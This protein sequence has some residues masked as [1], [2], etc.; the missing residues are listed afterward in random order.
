[1]KTAR[2]RR[3]L[4]LPDSITFGLREHRLRQLKES[5]AVGKRWKGPKPNEEG[6]HVFTTAIGTPLEARNI[7]RA[8]TAI[9][10]RAGLPHRR[11]AAS[12]L[13]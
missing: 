6:C 8:Y 3:T 2:S 7:V 9:V 5:L 11:S 4:A 12:A 10:K 1:L 13:P